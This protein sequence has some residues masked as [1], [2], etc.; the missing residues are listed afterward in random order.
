MNEESLW[1][2][3][4]LIRERIYTLWQS[5]ER[6]KGAGH[7]KNNIWELLKSEERLNIQVLETHR[8][9][10]KFN[11]KRSSV[12]HLIIKQSKTKGKESWKQQQQ[13]QKRKLVT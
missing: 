4:T 5:K 8:S 12:R 7:L 13:Q 6:E 9:V 11:Q 10:K 1:T 2:Y 3:G